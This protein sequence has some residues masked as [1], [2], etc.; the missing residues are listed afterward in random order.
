MIQGPEGFYMIYLKIIFDDDG[1]QYKKCAEFNS[2][3]RC[4]EILT[5]DLATNFHILTNKAY[6]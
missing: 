4:L 3:I 2:K 6:R 5:T 1:I